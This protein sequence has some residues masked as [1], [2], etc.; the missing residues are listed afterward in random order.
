[1]VG[2]GRGVR[3]DNRF[4]AS[5]LG[6]SRVSEAA[7]GMRGDMLSSSGANALSKCSAP[8][9]ARYITCVPPHVARSLIWF[10]ASV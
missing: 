10:A 5:G 9:M 6:G 4:E 7:A 8:N 1:M 2:R 3:L